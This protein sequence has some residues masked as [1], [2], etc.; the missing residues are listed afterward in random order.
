MMLTKAQEK[1]FE[2]NKNLVYKAIN[3]YVSNPGKY[4][5][6]DYEDLVSIGEFALCKAIST[7]EA[8][9]AA[10]S[11]YAI[12][13]IRNHL[14]NTIRDANETSDTTL[15]ITYDYVELNAN[16]AYNNISSMNDDILMKDGLNII[17]DCSEKY[18]GIAGKGAEALRLMLLGYS[19]NDIA[20]MYGVEDKTITAWISRARKKL[21]KEPAL[22]KLLDK[23]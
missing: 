7:Y 9:K 5:I 16:L 10:F 19:C 13:V 21:Q 2:E 12:N 11:S 20:K 4:G 3:T 8:D 18:G 1:I 23:A 22:L 6:N 15:S 17:S 14:Y